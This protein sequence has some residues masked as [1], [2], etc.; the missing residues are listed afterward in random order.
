ME[1]ELKQ[2]KRMSTSAGDMVWYLDPDAT[3]LPRDQ[4]GAILGLPLSRIC[5]Y[6]G[7]IRVSVLEHSVLVALLAER[8]C[9]DPVLTAYAA[10]HD[11]HEAIVGDWPSGLKEVVPEFKTRVEDPWECRV[12]VAV[13]LPWP[14][15]DEIRRWVRA[16][17]LR[18][19]VIEM[20]ACGHPLVSLAVE[21]YGGEP[22]HT[23]MGAWHEVKALG[24]PTMGG[25]E[26]L[27]A[28]L[29]RCLVAGALA[30]VSVAE[31]KGGSR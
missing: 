9:G 29:D 13:G 8:T 10:A 20:G 30:V 19:R 11:L 7:T 1:M 2:S 27:W 3:P 21:L 15:H 22:T 14:A 23:E 6:M 28:Y 24:Y 31:A 25:W 4:L 16:L 12:H 17:D 18:A 5:R 26:G